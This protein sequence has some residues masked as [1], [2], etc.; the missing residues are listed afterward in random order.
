MSRLLISSELEYNI[1]TDSSSSETD[2]S[3]Y[4][5]DKGFT[6]SDEEVDRNSV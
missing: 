1:V 6:T 3:K 2:D 5:S 4:D